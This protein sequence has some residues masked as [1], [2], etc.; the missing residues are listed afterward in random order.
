VIRHVDRAVAAIYA[1]V[2]FAVVIAPAIAVRWATVHGGMGDLDGVDLAAASAIIGAAHAMVAFIRLRDEE[3]TALRR[4]DMWIASL[5]ALVVLALGATLLL[6]LVLGSFA[7]EH[8]SLANRGYPV[9]ALWVGV[10]LLAV[11]LAEGVGRFVFW[12]LEPHPPVHLHIPW[13]VMPSIRRRSRDARSL[14]KR[15]RDPHPTD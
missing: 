1:I 9:V 4:L 8:S 14:R 2:C 3:R 15:N 10:Q 5:N 6:V 13:N 7:D 12:W 11:T